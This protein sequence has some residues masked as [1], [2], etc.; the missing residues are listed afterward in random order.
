MAKTN[1]PVKKSKVTIE[2]TTS[3]WERFKKKCKKADLSAS[4]RVRQLVA[5]DLKV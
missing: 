3:A 4:E 5:A 1:L 2:I